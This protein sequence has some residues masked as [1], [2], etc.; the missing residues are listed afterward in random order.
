MHDLLEIRYAAPD[1]NAIKTI[2]P[3]QADFATS[4]Y[5]DNPCPTDDHR[6]LDY[7]LHVITGYNQAYNFEG[8]KPLLTEQPFCMPLGSFEVEQELLTYDPHIPGDIPRLRYVKTINIVWMGR[9]DMIYS[10]QG[11]TFL[12]DHKTT[13]MMGA[14]YFDD[15]NM[16]TA[17][18]GYALGCAQLEDPYE[19]D[20]FTMNALALR[21]RTK[22]GKGVTFERK[23]FNI[24][25]AMIAEWHLDVRAHIAN[26]LRYLINDYTPKNTKSCI[27]KYGKCPYF[28][29]CTSAPELRSVL[30]NSNQFQDVT[31][32]PLN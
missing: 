20:S 16:S 8:L 14:T 9:I 28:E 22:S 17:M 18:I 26:F 23:H 25:E 3:L 15:F 11:K 13:S 5:E 2:E 30:L 12:M 7:A 29:V 24:T 4:F 32:S 10:Y 27:G 21:K 6:N 19:I 31:W 1:I